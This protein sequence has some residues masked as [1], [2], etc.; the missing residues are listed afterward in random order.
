LQILKQE[1][2]KNKILNLTKKYSAYRSIFEESIKTINETNNIK[3]NNLLNRLF[4]G[5]ND[6]VQTL[7]INFSKLHDKFSEGESV[8]QSKYFFNLDYKILSRKYTDLFK[9][10]ESKCE[11]LKKMQQ[12]SNNKNSIIEDMNSNCN[13]NSL[14]I[15]DSNSVG[16]DPNE[17]FLQSQNSF[18]PTTSNLSNLNLSN[19]VKNSNDSIMLNKNCN[20]AKKYSEKENIESKT[21]ENNVNKTF[22][23]LDPNI[24]NDF[25]LSQVKI[26]SENS[27]HFNNKSNKESIYN[28]NINLYKEEEDGEQKNAKIMLK[29]KYNN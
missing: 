1:N 27:L 12:I 11:E 8:Y 15:V 5:Y 29:S 18:I 25:N 20:Q 4:N 3:S 7:F 22:C 16:N 26:D 21:N 24:R 23:N 9:S 17:K 28:N 19:I 13:S 6:T 14:P 2:E 10:Y